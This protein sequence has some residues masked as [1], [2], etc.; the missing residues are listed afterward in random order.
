MPEVGAP[1]SVLVVDD[2]PD[3]L[4]ATAD[5]VEC[6]GYAAVVASSGEDALRVLGERDD[7]GLV[8]MDVQMPGL[9][10]IEVLEKASRDEKLKAIPI[11]LMTAATQ[12]APP[13]SVLVLKKPFSLRRLVCVATEHLGG[14]CPEG[15]PYACHDC[16]AGHLLAV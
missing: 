6:V 4:T 3:T 2:D 5:A 8:L 14:I 16:D 12:L 13:P 15:R 1:K 11:V 7:I 9:T 10:G